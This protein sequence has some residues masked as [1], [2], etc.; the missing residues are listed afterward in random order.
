[1]SIDD[2]DVFYCHMDLWRTD[3]ERENLQYQG[4]CNRNTLR[5]RVGA[6]NGDNSVAKDQ[7]VAN[8]LGNRFYIPLD[9]ELLDSHIPF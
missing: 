2:S 6:E 8:A 7:A 4:I 1:M 3:K 5:L 9:F